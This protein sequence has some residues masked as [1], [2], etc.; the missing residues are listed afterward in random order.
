[1]LIDLALALIAAVYMQSMLL[2][3]LLIFVAL[4]FAK[5]EK[6]WSSG[7]LK[8]GLMALGISILFGGHDD[9]DL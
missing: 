8:L 3:V 5:P 9:C 6:P 1:M 4:P 2:F 7:L